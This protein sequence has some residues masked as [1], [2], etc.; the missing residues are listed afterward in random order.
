MAPLAAGAAAGAAA[1]GAGV[2][3]VSS[4][5][6]SSSSSSTAQGQHVLHALG[7]PVGTR[8]RARFQ[9]KQD[10]TLIKS[11]TTESTT[12]I[13]ITNTTAAGGASEGAAGGR[14]IA[15]PN[16]PGRRIFS[17]TGAVLTPLAL[18]LA[19]ATTNRYCVAASVVSYAPKDL[20]RFVR[21]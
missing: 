11:T 14:P 9:T 2:V 4:S 19:K 12:I 3:V 10:G 17:A 16:K 15:P 13:N 1:G 20:S 5:S 6:S 18:V 7:S 21:R 8:T